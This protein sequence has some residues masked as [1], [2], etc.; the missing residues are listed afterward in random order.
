[1]QSDVGL[2]R[3]ALLRAEATLSDSTLPPQLARAGAVTEIDGLEAFE[4]T[5]DFALD[6]TDWAWEVDVTVTNTDVV[7]HTGVGLT[8]RVPRDALTFAT[9]SAT[10]GAGG[11]NQIVNNLTC[12]A[13]EFLAWNLG[14]LTAGQS[15]TVTIPN[16]YIAVP[17]AEPGE[18][19]TLHAIALG[20][21]GD[22][23]AVDH[24]VPEPGV[25]ASLF[26]GMALIAGLSRSR[27]RSGTGRT[28]VD[29]RAA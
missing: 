27:V 23:R 14:T 13:G 17:T 18:L 1:V 10:G 7:S 12:E 22:D 8:L 15:V 26:A 24:V 6:F 16:L 3:G 11:C 4:T 28:R 2:V 5:V 19:F 9:G 20:S 25:A 21:G 29:A